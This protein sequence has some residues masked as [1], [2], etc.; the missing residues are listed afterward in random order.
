[1]GMGRSDGGT[2]S[3]SIAPDWRGAGLGTQ[4]VAALVATP[5]ALPGPLW[6]ET[7]PDHHAS[8]AILRKNGFKPRG[9]REWVRW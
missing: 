1:M 6:A 4:L 2:L 7:H 9:S 3:Y 8:Q 5:H